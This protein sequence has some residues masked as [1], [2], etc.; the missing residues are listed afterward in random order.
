M[1]K[2]T[3]EIHNP[4]AEPDKASGKDAEKACAVLHVV[5]A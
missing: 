3:T 4:G 5:A 2:V 1:L